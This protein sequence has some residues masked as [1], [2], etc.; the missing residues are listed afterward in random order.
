[1]VDEFL[2]REQTFKISTAYCEGQVVLVIDDEPTVRML[3]A[4]VLND[5]GYTV[6]EAPDGPAGLAVLDSN[7]RIELLITGVGLPNGLNGRQVADAARVSRPDLEVSFVTGY[8][9][10]A[11]IGNGRLDDGTFV[12]SKPF[13][14]E[15]LAT[16]IREI[17]SSTGQTP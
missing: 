9:E 11:A 15:E 10:Y 12:M 14:I 13:Q 7:A 17:I 3:I 4:E 8:A 6:I 1:M 5:A 2:M 16:R